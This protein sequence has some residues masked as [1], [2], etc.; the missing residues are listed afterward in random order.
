[1][2]RTVLTRRLMLAGMTSV[3]GNAAFGRAPEVSERPVPRGTMP[4][5]TVPAR[6]IKMIGQS[7]ALIQKAKLG[8]ELGFAVSDVQTGEVLEARLGEKALPPAST[9]KAV[10]AI[11]AL[12]RLGTAHR[13][14]TQV[15]ATGPIRNGKLDGNLV[16]VGG[17]DPT[18][19][20]DRLADLAVL[21]REAG[22]T[23]VT[24][25]F[26]VWAGALPATDR[27]D[28]DQPEHV[29]YNPSVG[30]LN[31][32]FNRV[33][34]EWKR[35]RDDQYTMTMQARARR[36]R[37]STSVASMSIVDRKAP[38]YDH[39]TNGLQDHWTV[40]R[41]ALGRDGA[42]WLP[43]RYP[44]Q[45]AGDVFRT[46]ARSNGLVL[47]PPAV[48]PVLPDGTVIAAVESDTLVPMLQSMLKYSTNLTAEVTGLS[49]SLSRGR[50]V[51]SL[52][53][54]G[55]RM[56]SYVNASY[57]SDRVNFRDHS[58]LGY[59]STIAPVDMVRI[60][61]ANAGMAPM[62]K[63]VNLSLDK[64]RPAPDDV[65]VRAKTGT[66]NFVSTLAGFVGTAQGRTLSFAIFGADTARRDAI[67]PEQRER[68]AGARGW[69]RR[70]RQL[71]KELIR[72]WASSFA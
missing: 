71:Q 25:K 44:A 43:V 34:F 13:F 39:W 41:Q 6:P 68:P 57:R 16:L 27:I 19:D 31:L 26:L 55:V 28:A 7:E 63:T 49:A 11:Y 51:G 60:L 3:A 30:G 67:P 48:T 10:T 15:L 72:H 59:G 66:L 65:L 47:S 22:I 53:A 2:T 14:S 4:K 33:H 40:S 45:Y 62:L 50:P 58:G 61:S 24:G 21:V 38:V 9:L 69:S 64:K 32:N 18:L 12:D 56:G 42:R 35:L 17:G 1:M 70:S 5:A 8:G 20:T 29:S 37:P 36:F 23:E 46:L 54:S 52:A